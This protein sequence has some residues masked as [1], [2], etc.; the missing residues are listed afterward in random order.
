MASKNEFG[1]KIGL[2]AAT[3]GS[4]V[5]LGN[6]WRFPA[7]TQTNGGAAFLLLYILCVLLLGIPVMLA[8]FSLGRGGR[9]DAIGVFRKL[10]PD[11]KWWLTGLLAVI[12]SYIIICYYMVVAGWTLEYFIESIS[13]GLYNSLADADSAE[14][15]H[16]TF[17][18]KMDEYVSSDMRPLLFTYAM[19]ALNIAVLLGGVRKGIENL[20]NVLM[21]LLFVILLVLCFITLSLPGSGE[22]VKFFLTPDFSRI[23]PST[24]VNAL[25]QAF[26]SLS[27]GM[28]I[29]IT[30]SSYYPGDTK[31]V[32]TSVIVSLLSLLVAVLMGLIIFPAVKSFGLDSE[33]L[34]GATLV[35]VTL[36]EVFAN[37]P[38][39]QIWSSLFFLLLLVAALTSTISIAEV[40]VKMMIDRFSLSRKAGVLIVM[41]P[42]L[43]LSAVCSLSFGSLSDF[44]IFGLTVFDLFDHIT[45]NIFLPLVSLGVC[46]YMGWSAPKHLLSDELSNKGTLRSPLTGS[47]Q[48][49]IKYVAPILIA[50]ILISNYL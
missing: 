9:S 15:L 38:A 16:G 50:T 11:S 34:K 26:F 48:F 4:A 2:I 27:L 10:S 31:L 39:P 22:G 43:A 7:E 40:S 42:L 33:P 17:A 29:L 14:A 6:V 5:G 47:I 25:G 30:Y 32:K 41:L 35:F 23:T 1:T 36:P 45:T 12:A 24:V 20:S 19:I 49:I 3:V 13:G 44:R 37:L 8:E 46:I 18:A 21:P 28:G